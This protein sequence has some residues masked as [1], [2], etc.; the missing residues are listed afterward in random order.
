MSV[1]LE[2]VYARARAVDSTGNWAYGRREIAK[3]TGVSE[4]QVRKVLA[5]VRTTNRVTVEKLD[6]NPE[7]PTINI[8]LPKFEN[9][10]LPKSKI[11]HW[12]IGSDFHVPYQHEESCNIFYQVIADLNPSKVILLG[13]ML[14]LDQFSRYPGEG[15]YPGA[16]TWIDEIAAVGK[17][18]G[19]V[20]QASRSKDVELLWFEGNH[21]LR[22]K[23]HLM[24]NDPI[25]YSHLDIASL[26]QLSKN[27]EA[28]DNF[29]HFEYI[30][31]P[32]KYYP[33][34][35]LVVKH[36]ETVRK[37]AGM[38]AA[39][40][41]DS[42]LTSVIM[43]HCHRLG[44]YRRSSG[45]TRYSN[46]LPLFGMET[47]CMCDYNLPYV[48]GSTSNWQHGFG[49]L[50]IDNQNLIVEPEMVSINNG[51]ALFRGVTYRG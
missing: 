35:N 17:I 25:L 39:A 6:P 24:R 38:S 28:Q 36:G 42:L 23:K 15:K 3:A 9:R 18:L 1:N 10:D 49:V 30:D 51:D 33:N 41:V 29:G 34:Q 8:T 50:T 40:E 32:E 45:R 22:L 47:G 14:N 27:K 13:D 44:I 26:F 19:N 43:G 20:L 21:E 37:H 12:V 48:E 11:E 7:L 4:W 31:S 2:E 16:P 46:E 5:E